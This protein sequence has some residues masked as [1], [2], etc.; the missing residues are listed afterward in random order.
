[1]KY[2]FFSILLFSLVLA[3][4]YEL[5][6][7]VNDYAG[8]IPQNYSI[9]IEKELKVLYDN[10]TAQIAVVTIPSLDGS[11]IQGYAMKMSEGK[12]GEIGKNNGLLIL[13]SLQEKKYWFNVGR[14]LEGELN[15]AKVGRIGREILVPNFKSG[16]YGKGIY[17]AVVAVRQELTNSTSTQTTTSTEQ[18]LGTGILIMIIIGVVILALVLK[19]GVSSSGDSVYTTMTTGGV[20]DSYSRKKKKNDDSDYFVAAGALS[21]ASHSS[22]SSSSGGSSFGGFGGGGFGGGGAGGGW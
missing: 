22:S 5:N 7:F 10:H 21:S 13:V 3:S 12:L 16:N 4:A 8:I 1:M 14:G 15:D 9:Q 18:P 17:E 2:L 20:S 6:G 11:D 19:D